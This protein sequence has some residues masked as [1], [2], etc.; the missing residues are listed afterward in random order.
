MVEEIIITQGLIDTAPEPEFLVDLHQRPLVGPSRINLRL[1]ED[2]A[3][4][5][6]S[7]FT[8]TDA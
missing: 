6:P 4:E 8:C 2:G 5:Y 7:R 3:P 1:G